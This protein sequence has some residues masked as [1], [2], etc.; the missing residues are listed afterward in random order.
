MVQ[1]KIKAT[2]EHFIFKESKSI[3]NINKLNNEINEIRKSSINDFSIRELSFMIE[4]LKSESSLNIIAKKLNRS[5][6]TVKKHFNRMKDYQKY[7]DKKGKVPICQHCKKKINS[8]S[9]LSIEYWVYKTKE[10]REKPQKIIKETTK[11][12]YK[13]MSDFFQNYHR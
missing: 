5:I 3:N 2:Y 12:I 1:N 8:A 11:N 13:P 4:L 6:K 9:V 7:I 10:I